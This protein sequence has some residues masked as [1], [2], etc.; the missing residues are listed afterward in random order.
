[1]LSSALLSTF[2][3]VQQLSP[4]A[5]FCDWDYDALTVKAMKWW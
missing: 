1:M 3:W 5:A 2:L 4:L